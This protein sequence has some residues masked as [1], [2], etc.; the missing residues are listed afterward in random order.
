[1]IS[2]LERCLQ[3]GAIATTVHHLLCFVRV[4]QS[5]VSQVVA[6]PIFGDLGLSSGFAFVHFVSYTQSQ[7]NVPPKMLIC[8]FSLMQNQTLNTADV[9]SS[10]KL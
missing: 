1:M 7:Q 4:I 5:E 8:E 10:L 6:R 2:L 9:P 3:L